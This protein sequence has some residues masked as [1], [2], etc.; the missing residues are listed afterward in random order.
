VASGE[1]RIGWPPL[2]I[3]SFPVGVVIVLSVVVV[4]YDHLLDNR[5]MGGNCWGGPVRVGVSNRGS[6]SSGGWGEAGSTTAGGIGVIEDGRC[7]WD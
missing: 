1:V 2:Q 3:F 6:D 4:G 7:C 5:L